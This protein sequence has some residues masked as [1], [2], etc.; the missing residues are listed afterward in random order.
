MHRPAG[1]LKFKSFRL[2]FFF[3]PGGNIKCNARLHTVSFNWTNITG[4]LNK[5]HH[6]VATE[7]EDRMESNFAGKSTRNHVYRRSTYC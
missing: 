1:Y 6:L 4:N 2:M 7:K 5:F 3:I